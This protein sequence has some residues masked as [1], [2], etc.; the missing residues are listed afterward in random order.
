[1]KEIVVKDKVINI[2]G[3][4][5]DD[6]VSL[7][8]IAKIKNSMFPSDVIKNWLRLKNTV[9]FIGLWEQINNDGFKLVEFDRIKIEAGSNAFVFFSFCIK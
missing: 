6:Y 3:I 9:E 2:T 4:S 5:D 8:D 7:T 1:M